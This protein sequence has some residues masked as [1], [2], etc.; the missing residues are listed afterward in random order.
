MERRKTKNYILTLFR[1]RVG[2]VTFES[3]LVT[4]Y[5]LHPPCNCKF[6]YISVTVTCIFK[7]RRHDVLLKI[8]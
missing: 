4:S 1:D 2:E 6:R 7:A 3:N 8:C 5:K